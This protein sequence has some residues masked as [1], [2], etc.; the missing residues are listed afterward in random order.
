[1]HINQPNLGHIL[2]TLLAPTILLGCSVNCERLYQEKR[3]YELQKQELHCDDVHK[4]LSSRPY[5]T[6]PGLLALLPASYPNSGLGK[7]LQE[8]RENLVTKACH[9]LDQTISEVAKELERHCK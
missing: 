5:E 7:Q 9:T 4:H 2:L 8:E 1:M 3:G 6:T